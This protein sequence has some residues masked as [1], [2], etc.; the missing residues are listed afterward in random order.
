MTYTL[1]PDAAPVNRV[2]REP[3]DWDDGVA[4][5]RGTGLRPE[6]MTEFRRHIGS[7]LAGVF[8]AV[9]FDEIALVPIAASV[10]R[11]G[12][13]RNNFLDRGL[14]SAFGLMPALVGGREQRREGAAYLK[15]QHRAVRGTGSGD[16]AGVRYSALDP[17][18]WLWI[19]A[20]GI[21]LVMTTFT[22]CTG[23]V[24]SPA[25]REAAYQYLRYLFSELELPS[26]K[27]KLPATEADF[28]E[29]YDHMVS[30]R[31]QTNPLLRDLFA[32]LTSLP[33]P[34][35][36]TPRPLR[37]A[38]AP[39]WFA[40]R[41]FVGRMIQICS[42]RTMHPAIAPMVGYQPKRHHAVEFALYVAAL[43]VTWR[44]IPD[45]LLLEPVSYNSIRIDRLRA[46]KHRSPRAL[47]RY[48]RAAE[49]I[50]RHNDRILG[51]Y[52]QHRLDDYTPPPSQGSCPF[53]GAPGSVTTT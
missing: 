34:T 11:T 31:L 7:P 18:L 47:R 16:Y 36:F 33:L 17:E 19:A 37:I 4:L 22:P 50:E 15:E 49:R 26:A 29:Y 45:R 3:D 10:D 52:R 21:H 28:T 14:Q 44:L 25:E 23:T 9:L 12:R 30:T 5:L 24:L 39:L 51:F 46:R 8:G 48:E 6:V 20:S 32:G 38:L 35:L 42:A 53:G 1:N 13:F 43:R 2:G 40:I 41:P 27:G